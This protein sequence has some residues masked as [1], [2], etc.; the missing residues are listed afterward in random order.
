MLLLVI[1][2]KVCYF[3]LNVVIN[4]FRVMH[5]YCVFSWVCLLLVFLFVRGRPPVWR[6]IVIDFWCQKWDSSLTVCINSSIGNTQT[7]SKGFT[8]AARASDY[9]SWSL[10][11][12][13]DEASKRSIYFSSKDAV[14][15]LASKLRVFDRLAQSL[16]DAGGKENFAEESLST[17]LSFEQRLQLQEHELQMLELRRKISH[18]HREIRELE[19]EL[20]RDRREAERVEE[21]ERREYE[22]RKAQE[23]EEERRTLEEERVRKLQAEKEEIGVR[24]LERRQ[25]EVKRPKFIKIREMR[26]GGIYEMTAKAQSLPEGE[27]VGNLVPKLNEKAKSIYL[28]IPDPACQDYNETKA[29]IIKAYQLTTNHYRYRFQTSEK[30]PD[31]DFVQWGNRTRRYLNRW[32]AVAEATGDAENIIKQIMIERLLDAVSPELRAWLKEQKPKTAEE[33]GNLANLHVQSRKGPLVGGKYVSTGE[34][35]GKKKKSD[36]KADDSFSEEKQ[37]QNS[38]R[39]PKSPSLSTRRNTRP[40]IKCYKCSKLGHMSFNCGRGRGKSSQAYLLYMT[41]LASEQSEI[42]PFCVRGKINGKRAEM[43]VDS[44]CTRTL[45]HKKYV[46]DSAFTG[47]KFTVLIATSECPTVPI[48]NVEFVSEEGKHAEL[49]GVLDSLPVDCLLGRSSFEKTLSKQDILD[50]WEK[51]LSV[52]D[53]SGHKVFVMTQR[54]RALEDAQTRADELIDRESSLAVKNLSKKEVKPNAPEIGDLQLLFEGNIHEDIAKD[55]ENNTQVTESFKDN[56]PPNI[57]D[58][59]R[60]QLIL[61]QKSD[62]TLEKIYCEATGIAPEESDGYFST[63]GVLMHRKY[64]TNERNGTRY[65]DR[66]VVPESYRNEILRICH[67]IPLSGHMGRKKTLERITVHFFWPGLHFDVRKYCATCPQCQVVARKFKSRRAPLKPVDLVTEPF[68]KI[69]IDIIGVLP[70]TT[71]GYKY[72][73][74]TVDYATRYPEAIPMR[75][76]NSKTIAD[77]LIQ[78]FS[79]VGIPDEIVSD[80]GSKF[81]S[82]LMAQLYNQ[83]G[84]T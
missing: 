4:T 33:P 38:E 68:K 30:K 29:I 8:M 56:P 40:E 20:E 17:S 28:E 78:Y 32:M 13:R 34:R 48:A 75:S 62:V 10:Q 24:G 65:V 54:Q 71:T 77:A 61:D 45:V 9:D 79:R 2:F 57:L 22:R 70:R 58:R 26:E 16:G 11:D 51:N 18:E 43:V 7:N 27:W 66:V 72:I 83:L 82:K 3:N 41:P 36:N 60:N 25:R 47:D 23:E 42:S 35:F 63:N 50:Q 74:T 21:R 67:T 80:Q 5:S 12:L 31:E 49:V 69:S 1:L 64:L 73:L 81:M 44:G 37:E 76:T 46:S 52:D 39:P 84:I 53:D 15:T 55:S 6:A 19:R 59:N 14:K